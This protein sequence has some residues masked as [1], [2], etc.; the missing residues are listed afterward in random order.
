VSIASLAPLPGDSAA[1]RAA[2]VAEL[3]LLVDLLDRGLCEPLPLYCK[4][5]AAWAGSPPAKRDAACSK[6]WDPTSD[7]GVSEAKE[8]EHQLVLG[9]V[10]P[11]TDVCLAAPGPGESGDGW[12]A[13]EPSR[14]GR[15]ARRLWG[16]LLA[17]EEVSDR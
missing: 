5:S 14:F 17:A 7:F 8:P 1:R 2:A 13:G 4:T 12:V 10:V 15:Y 16:G 3:E 9:G 6:L 11:F